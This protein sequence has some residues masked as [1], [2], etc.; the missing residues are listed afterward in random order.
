MAILLVMLPAGANARLQPNAVAELARLGIT[1]V[2]V[3]RDQRSIGVVVEGW[4]FDPIGSAEGVLAAICGRRR[5]V[6]T[7]RP[8]M[9]LT[10]AHG[11]G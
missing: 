10:L 8:V 6:R 9:E 5:G 1:N 3:V 7:L 2:A 11:E 4:G